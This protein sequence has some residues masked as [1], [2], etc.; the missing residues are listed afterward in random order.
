MLIKISNIISA[1]MTFGLAA[2]AALCIAPPAR[3]GTAPAPGHSSA[4]G[5]TLAGWE[6]IYWRW[7]FGDITVPAD[8]NGNAVVGEGTVLLA[9]PSAPGDGSPGHLAV[10]LN[11]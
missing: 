3:G 1:G 10:T 11:N 8:A 2:I 4:F 5:N 9:I 7:A 6:E